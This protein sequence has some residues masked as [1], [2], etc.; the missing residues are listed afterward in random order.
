MLSSPEVAETLRKSRAVSTPAGAAVGALGARRVSIMMLSRNPSAVAIPVMPIVKGLLNRVE[1]VSHKAA[2]TRQPTVQRL[3]W[4]V[5][6]SQRARAAV[7]CSSTRCRPILGRTATDTAANTGVSGQVFGSRGAV[8]QLQVPLV[9]LPRPRNQSYLPG[10]VVTPKLRRSEGGRPF[11]LYGGPGIAATW[12][13]SS[14]PSSVPPA[15]SVYNAGWGGGRGLT[16]TRPRSWIRLRRC[17]R[18]SGVP[19]GPCGARG[20]PDRTTRCAGTD[21]RRVGPASG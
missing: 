19:R 21:R 1:D 3:A 10:K 4:A 9:A 13:R 15:A 2:E 20:S 6:G 11:R 18:N 14:A 7:S 12:P 17:S 5:F 16:P 8:P